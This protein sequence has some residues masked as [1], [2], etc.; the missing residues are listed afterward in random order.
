M[1]D[2]KTLTGSKKIFFG[3]IAVLGALVIGFLVVEGYVRATS[4][5]IDLWKITGR[6]K[7]RDPMERWAQIDAFS[8]YRGR[9]GDYGNKA[10]KSINRHGFISTPDLNVNKEPDEIRIAFLGGSSTAGTGFDLPDRETWPWKVAEMVQREFPDKKVTFINAALGGYASFESYGRF[11]SRVR[12]F[13]PDIVVVNHGWNE[14]YYFTGEKVDTIHQWRTLPDG[15]W[16]FDNAKQRQIY[17]PLWIDSLLRYSQLL[18]RL[19][20]HKKTSGE[21]GGDQKEKSL[22]IDFDKRGLEI[23]RTNLRLLRE[24]AK[25]FGSEL[26]VCKQPTLLVPGLPEEIRARMAYHYHGFDH[27]A[28]V[29]AFD[30]LYRV[31]DEEIAKNRVIDLTPLSGQTTYFY[32]HVHPTSLGTTKIAEIVS[33]KLIL[34][35][36]TQSGLPTINRAN[37]NPNE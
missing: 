23:W 28:H 5:N 17:A 21:I 27:Y 16:G 30:A 7:G 36:E 31:I 2:K 29:R 14:M 1:S 9:P 26:F 37:R 11:W 33:S 22:A 3:V 20:I 34:H 35:I 25:V 8:A 18:I 12:F 19:R 15:S 10:N 24:A 4:E 6:K 32:D 13:N